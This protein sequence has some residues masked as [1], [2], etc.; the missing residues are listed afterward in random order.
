[1]DRF[2][3]RHPRSERR[4]EVMLL[5]ANLDRDRGDCASAMERYRT[6]SKGTGAIADDATYFAAACAQ[7]LGRTEEA[8]AL[9]QESLQRFPS[10][11]HADDARRA[12]A[13]R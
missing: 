1:M 7:Q 6:L 2:L 10:G 12:L 5:R 4:D 9:L 13:G 11:R 8:R 3:T